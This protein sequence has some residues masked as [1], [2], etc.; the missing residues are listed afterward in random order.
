MMKK[1][2]WFVAIISV[3][4][5]QAQTQGEVQAKMDSFQAWASEKFEIREMNI[6]EPNW[7]ALNSSSPDY[8]LYFQFKSLEKIDNNIERRAYNHFDVALYYFSEEEDAAYALDSWLKSF[9]EGKTLRKGRPMRAYEYAKPT[10]VLIDE[11]YIA[12]LQMKCSD[13]FP[14]EYDNWVSAMEK[15]LGDFSTMTIELNCEGPLAWTKNAPDPKAKRN[16]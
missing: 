10:I 14:E 2:L 7:G 13:F 16:R 8:H 5:L 6:E 12:I 15:H 11:K 1:I 4:R 3:F 9:M